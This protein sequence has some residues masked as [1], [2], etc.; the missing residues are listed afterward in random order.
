MP[1]FNPMTSTVVEIGCLIFNT[2]LFAGYH[3]YLFWTI[4]KRPHATAAGQNNLTRQTWCRIIMEHGKDVLAIQ[5]LRNSMMSSSLLATTALTL[6]SVIAAFFIKDEGFSRIEEID[7]WSALFSFEHKLFVMIIL[8]MLSFFS[9]MQAVRLA[10]HAG[11]ML[12]VPPSGSFVTSEK[13]V[14]PEYVSKILFRSSLYHT[15]GTRMFYGAFL[16]V[17]WIFGPIAAT[18]AI[19]VLLGCLYWADFASIDKFD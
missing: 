7:D 4:W 6:S 15:V 10:S 18:S 1:A 11:Y 8:F 19:I 12:A 16:T 9:F 3:G 13:F 5:T 17:I 14:T 2:L